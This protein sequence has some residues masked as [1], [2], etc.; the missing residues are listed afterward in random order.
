MSVVELGVSMPS[1][2]GLS[3][4]LGC[5]VTLRVRLRSFMAVKGTFTFFYGS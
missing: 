3:D 4:V 5:S 1:L 2:L